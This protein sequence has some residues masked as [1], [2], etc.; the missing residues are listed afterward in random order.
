MLSFETIIIVG[1][2]LNICYLN[3]QGLGICAFLIDR[4]VFNVQKTF[5]FNSKGKLDC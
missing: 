5:C 2:T 3:L 4:K 1:E